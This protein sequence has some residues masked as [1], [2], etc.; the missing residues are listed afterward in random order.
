MWEHINT[1]TV[2]GDET[3]QIVFSEDVNGNPIQLKKFYLYGY[4]I[5]GIATKFVIWT[6]A[7]G[8]QRPKSPTQFTSGNAVTIGCLWDASETKVAKVTFENLNKS[9]YASYQAT[10]YKNVKG[11]ASVNTTSIDYAPI[12]S[13]NAAWSNNGAINNGA[14][15]EL[16]GV[17]M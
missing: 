11:L 1:I 7:S 3:T 17:R 15:F 12:T 10:F 16:Y 4:N 8:W 14:V 5:T 2:S 9:T 6:S 13:V